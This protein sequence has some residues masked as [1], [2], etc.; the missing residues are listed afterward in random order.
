MGLFDFFKAKPAPLR[1]GDNLINVRERCGILLRSTGREWVLCVIP[2]WDDKNPVVVNSPDLPTGHRVAGVVVL[3]DTDDGFLH[4]ATVL[5]TNRGPL[6]QTYLLDPDRPMERWPV[7]GN[8]SEPSPLPT[9]PFGSSQTFGALTLTR[10]DAHPGELVAEW[11]EFNMTLRLG[12]SFP[13]SRLMEPPHTKV[14]AGVLRPPETDKEQEDLRQAITSGPDW[15]L[16]LNT[17]LLYLDGHGGQGSALITFLTGVGIRV[18]TV[19]NAQPPE[20]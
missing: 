3:N 18:I 12:R 20:G 6:P 10:V 13:V 5:V 11:P 14:F 19:G 7:I 2:S 1:D 9:A 4:V 16:E 15:A 8:V 17:V